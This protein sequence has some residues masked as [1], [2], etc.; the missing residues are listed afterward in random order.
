MSSGG[1]EKPLAT[2]FFFD[3]LGL[4]TS[5]LFL[6]SVVVNEQ[7]TYPNLYPEAHSVHKWD[8]TI[9]IKKVLISIYTQKH[10]MMI[11]DCQS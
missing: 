9:M 8:R 3:I 10:T 7:T 4:P 11:N 6:F 5:T 1:L 2:V